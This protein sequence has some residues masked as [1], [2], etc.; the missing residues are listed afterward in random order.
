MNSPTPASKQAKVI[1]NANTQKTWASTETKWLHRGSV[2]DSPMSSAYCLFPLF[3][4]SPVFSTYSSTSSTNTI[5]ESSDPKGEML[6]SVDYFHLALPHESLS[7][8]FFHPHLFPFSAFLFA[9]QLDEK[10]LQVENMLFA[11]DF[12]KQPQVFS[13]WTPFWMLAWMHA[14]HGRGVCHSRGTFCHDSDTH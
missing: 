2:C 14:H 8:L 5:Y 9:S 12:C 11:I 7:Q 13:K 10:K 1:L 4:L 3:L 6:H